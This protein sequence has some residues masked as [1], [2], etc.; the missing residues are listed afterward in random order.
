MRPAG[1]SGARSHGAEENVAAGNRNATIQKLTAAAKRDGTIVAL[2]GEFVNALGWGGWSASTDGPM[3]ML[4][5]CDNVRTVMYAR[6][7]TRRR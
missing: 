4:Y 3:R 5:A 1:R 6:S 2:G 7:S